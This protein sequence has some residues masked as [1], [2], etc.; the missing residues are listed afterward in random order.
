MNR[1]LATVGGIALCVVLFVALNILGNTA[2]RGA[3]LDLTE[4]K[5]Y[6]LTAGS[7]SIAR[8]LEE[9]VTL[10]LYVS[11]KETNALPIYKAYATRVREVLREYAGASGGK[12]KLE[13]VN[14]EPFSD[15]EDKAVEAGLFGAQ[16]GPAGERLYFGLVGVNS[17]GKKE[18]IPF[19]QPEREEVLEYDITR[20]IYLL[21]NP[22]KKVVGLM[23]SLPV[24][25]VENNPLMGGQN[26]PPWQIVTQM[27][28]LFEVK[29]VAPDAAEIPS[30]IQ[31]LMV[32]HPKSLP[33][34]AQFLIDQFVLKGGRLLV[35]VD[36]W[37]EADV[38]PGINP[39]QAMQLPRASGLPKLFDAWGFEMIP[40][41]FAGDR[42]AA[43]RVTMGSQNRPE[44]VDYVG[45]LDLQKGRENLVTGDSVT[46]S[47]EKL[48]MATAGVLRKKD[49]ATVSFDPL[50]QTSPDSQT[51]DTKLV[52]FMPD[53]KKLLADFVPGDEKLTL[54]ARIS[55]KV[56]TAFP[57]GDPAKPAD[58]QPAHLT[59]SAET[60]NIIVVADC[61]MLHDRFWVQENRIG[62]LMLG[63]SKV[64]DNG[65]L[66]IGALDNLTGSSD[67]IS[68]RARGKF[69]RPFDRVETIRKDA[70]AKFLAKQETLQKEL[71]AAQNRIEELKRQASPGSTISIT[72]EQQA[73]I[74]K[75]RENAVAI[76]KQLRDVQHQLSKDIEALGTRLKFINIGAMPVAVGLA[77]V[78]LSV[79]R[80][81]R[82]RSVKRRG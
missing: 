44:P 56:K 18:T 3:R 68:V 77:A 66:V 20:L 80:S 67:L 26:V 74:Q 48:V 6:T 14:P 34:R 24:N 51:I 2:L 61:D 39:M 64:S 72:P 58:D 38:P 69:S 76:R 28:E 19:F 36:P 73:E 31:A 9:P 46:G 4:N 49:G 79:Y 21:S 47:L 57:G 59:E 8:K 33:D 63:Y 42:K 50:I 40:E 81:G 71:A 22:P 13:V 70:E 16:V 60:A 78:G 30:D 17:I 27:K 55:G 52:Q 37:C 43:I 15:A 45:W 82:R 75:S 25:G 1:T 35:F 41:R 5:L 10:T 11:D 54:A 32:V 29:T 62:N 65:D 53:P 23:A 7:R 12:I